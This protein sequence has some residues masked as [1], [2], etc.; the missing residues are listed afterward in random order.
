MTNIH[1]RLHSQKDVF[2]SPSI[3]PS[4]FTEHL[5]WA[6]PWKSREQKRYS[7]G[8][9]KTYTLVS[10]KL[11]TYMILIK[12]KN[13]MFYAVSPVTQQLGSCALLQQPRA[14]R[15]D[16]RH[17]HTH[18][19]SSYTAAGIPHIK[20][21]GRRARMV[22][23]GQFSS[24]KRGGLVVDVSSRLIF[25]SKIKKY[26]N[27]NKINHK[28]S[29]NFSAGYTPK[30]HSDPSFSAIGVQDLLARPEKP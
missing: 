1:S 13:K 19:S 21:G 2:L 28:I 15:S 25:L 26:I 24:A 12:N 16:P 29:K 30:V 18:G 5:L 6:R 10:S 8:L 23:Q 20:N 7:Q 14:R 27:K 22:A 4:V 9:P 11:N 17:G 3:H